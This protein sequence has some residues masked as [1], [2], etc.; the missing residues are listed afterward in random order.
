MSLSKFARWAIP[1]L[2]VLLVAA[3]GW[4]VWRADD[5]PASALD[6]GSAAW[7]QAALPLLPEPWPRLPEP[8]PFRDGD[9]RAR[10]LADEVGRDGA[11]LVVNFWAT[12][13]PPCVREMPALDALAGR[14]EAEGLPIRVLTI[15]TR[16]PGKVAP[17]LAANGLDHL[18]GHTDPGGQLAHI[19]GLSGLPTTLVVRPDGQVA[20]VVRGEAAWDSPAM[21]A[22]LTRLAE[23]TP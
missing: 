10:D 22:A 21:V 18:P 19:L 5:A 14:A 16:D 17:F 8:T 7:D 4:A 20:A 12:W 13:C 15:S 11:L 6:T 2:G 3:V 1:L 9:G 23:A